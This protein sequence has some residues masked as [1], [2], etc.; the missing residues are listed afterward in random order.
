MIERQ[1]NKRKEKEKFRL[2]TSHKSIPSLILIVS[3]NQAQTNKEVISNVKLKGL[4]LE[5]VPIK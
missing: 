1:K 3:L 5:E 2:D 4:G